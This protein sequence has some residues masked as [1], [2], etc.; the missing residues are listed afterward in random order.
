MR[1][2]C[3]EIALRNLFAFEHESL[4]FDCF[5]SESKLAA[6]S[7]GSIRSAAEETRAAVE[8]DRVF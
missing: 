4:I 8:I 2:A 1:L 3:C 5:M 7:T 6:D